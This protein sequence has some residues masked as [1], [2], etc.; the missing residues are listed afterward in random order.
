[1]SD[2]GE[3]ESAEVQIEAIKY[4]V[5]KEEIEKIEALVKE[6]ELIASDVNSLQQGLKS[7]MDRGHFE[8]LMKEKTQ[9]F[10]ELV[11]EMDKEVASDV[12]A[13]MTFKFPSDYN[14]IEL[15]N[16]AEHKK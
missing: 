8:S 15:A 14:L 3:W 2:Y 1:M 4:R 6:I 13:A 9:K 16:I 12:V 10:R 5:S 11:L 7:G